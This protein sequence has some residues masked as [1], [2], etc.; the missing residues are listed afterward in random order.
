MTT[1]RLFLI[2]SLAF[3]LLIGFR[4]IQDAKAVQYLKNC[5]EV[6]PGMT[7]AQ[8]ELIMGDQDGANH[9]VT[10]N[11]L[12][13]ATPMFARTGT[14]IY[15]DPQSKTVTEVICGD[16]KWSGYNGAILNK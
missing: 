10:D 6:E 7:V 5:Q 15:F 13:Y 12:K 4:I 11:A 8:A 3:F 16:T 2:F 9:R 14:V 1:R